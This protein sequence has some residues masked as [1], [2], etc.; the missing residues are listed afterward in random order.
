MNSSPKVTWQRSRV[1]CDIEVKEPKTIEAQA[2]AEVKPSAEVR[3]QG[4]LD[5]ERRGITS[6]SVGFVCVDVENVP[7]TCTVST[8][9]AC[10]FHS[11]L[12]SSVPLRFD[13]VLRFSLP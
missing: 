3:S 7:F 8:T 2:F 4:S 12:R 5:R 1:R 11:W 9:L 10:P 6:G 13:L